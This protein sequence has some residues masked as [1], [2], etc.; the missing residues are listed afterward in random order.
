[1]PFSK[2]PQIVNFQCLEQLWDGVAIWTKMDVSWMTRHALACAATLL[3][4]GA[5]LP[6]FGRGGAAAGVVAG[7]LGKQVARIKGKVANGLA[8]PGG[9]TLT[10]WVAKMTIGVSKFYDFSLVADIRYR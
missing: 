3:P 1:M 4:D 6:S 7:H 9:S 10:L 5:A 8:A 2:N